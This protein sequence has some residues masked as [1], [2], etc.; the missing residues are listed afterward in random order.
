LLEAESQ[1]SDR[2]EPRDTMAPGAWKCRITARNGPLAGKTFTFLG[3]RI[4]IGR[5]K[6]SK[7]HLRDEEVSRSHAC[8]WRHEGDVVIE[9]LKSGNG[10]FLNGVAV[11]RAPLKAG[12]VIRIG[13]T[14]F[15]VHL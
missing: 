12:D 7:I 14:E 9:D 8:I 13:S 6:K 3:K 2:D 15:L 11:R 1:R 4:T 5:G 10:V